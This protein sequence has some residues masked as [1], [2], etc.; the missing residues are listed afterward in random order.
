MVWLIPVH[1]ANEMSTFLPQNSSYKQ[2]FSPFG[3]DLHIHS[4]ALFFYPVIF[5]LGQLSDDISFPISVTV[6]LLGH[7]PS[8]VR[9]TWTESSLMSRLSLNGYN[10]GTKK[11]HH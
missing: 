11:Y 10:G 9:P 3:L 8:K 5:I 6:S 2:C 1:V 4:T 7:F